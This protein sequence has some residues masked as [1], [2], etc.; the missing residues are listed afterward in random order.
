MK[1]YNYHPLTGEYISTDF[2]DPNPLE[3]GKYLIPA[4][5]TDIMPPPD[6]DGKVKFFNELSKKWEYAKLIEETYHY[7]RSLE[8]P[9]IQD[10]LD[11]LYHIGYDGWKA[12]IKEIKEKY[13]K[14]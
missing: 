12:K 6:L 13:P 11:L 3:P 2:A 8:Y 1:I 10:Q 4:N 7:K 9:S 14:E 5:A